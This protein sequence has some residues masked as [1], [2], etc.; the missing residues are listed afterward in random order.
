MKSGGLVGIAAT[1]DLEP[2]E[3][4]IEIPEKLTVSRKSILKSEIGP[5][6]D[7]H[8]EIFNKHKEDDMSLVLYIFH[9][10]LKG[11]KSFWL[12]YLNIINLSD[13]PAFWDEKM[14]QEF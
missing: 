11:E 3:K 10:K 8:P 2:G 1:K 5:L 14:K 7:Q 4:Y 12:P 13:L 6:I 9:E